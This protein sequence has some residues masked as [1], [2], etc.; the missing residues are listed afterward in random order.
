MHAP[1]RH[2]YGRYKGR[3]IGRFNPVRASQAVLPKLK[4][5]QTDRLANLSIPDGN[6]GP[7]SRRPRQQ[8]LLFHARFNPRREPGAF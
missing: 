8:E 3:V 2:D 1:P 4:V 5:Q 7:F 6:Q